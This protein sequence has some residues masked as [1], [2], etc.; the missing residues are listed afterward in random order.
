MY[1]QR[2]LYIFRGTHV[3]SGVPD[4]STSRGRSFEPAAEQVATPLCRPHAA[5]VPKYIILGALG[6][7]GPFCPFLGHLSLS[8]APFGLS[9]R[10]TDTDDITL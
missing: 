7:G 4:R 1:F 2:Y 5:P 8:F 3:F 6:P 10:A 9:N